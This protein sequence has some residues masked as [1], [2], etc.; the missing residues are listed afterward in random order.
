MHLTEEDR[1]QYN[2]IEDINNSKIIGAVKDIISY[3]DDMIDYNLNE[4]KDKETIK[5]IRVIVRNLNQFMNKSIK[6]IDDDTLIAIFDNP[7]CGLDWQL[8]EYTYI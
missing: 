6:E 8:I 3:L 7:M 1:L 2:L 5:D 4:T